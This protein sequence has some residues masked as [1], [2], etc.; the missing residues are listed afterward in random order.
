MTVFE[1][2]IKFWQFWKRYILNAFKHER[3][4][5]PIGRVMHSN[6][7]FK[8]HNINYLDYVEG[9]LIDEGWQPNYFSFADLGQVTSMRK[10]FRDSDGYWWQDHVRIHYDGE[11]RGHRELS[12]EECAITH[13]KG[14]TAE[15]LPFMVR[16]TLMVALNYSL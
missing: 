16:E 12:Y 15:E 2:K 11:V 13:I 6:I 4:G 8:K 1:L 5:F 7:D 10:M 3:E 9:V 14:S